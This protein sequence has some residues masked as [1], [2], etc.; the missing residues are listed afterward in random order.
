MY[1]RIN[2]GYLSVNIFSGAARH[3]PFMNQKRFTRDE[4]I[5]ATENTGACLAISLVWWRAHSKTNGTYQMLNILSI[6]G[7]IYLLILIGYVATRSGFFARSDMQVIGRYVI[8]LAIPALLFKVSSER[9]LG[10]IFNPSYLL[11]YLAGSLVMV[12]GGYWW[13]RTSPG[14]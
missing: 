9:A 8:N 14:H 6:T 10:E 13:S 12:G 7:P 2:S 1:S 11:A 3:P 4:L 5:S